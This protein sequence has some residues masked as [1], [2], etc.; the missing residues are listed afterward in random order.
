VTVTWQSVVG[1]SYFIERST[2]LAVAPAFTLL[3]TN[4]V[5]EINTKNFTDTN[6]TGFTPLFYRVGVR[7]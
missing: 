1:V 7:P 5:G 6:V 3:A 2:N 4:L